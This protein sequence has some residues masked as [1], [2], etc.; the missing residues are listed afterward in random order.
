MTITHSPIGV[1]HLAS[2]V[3]AMLLG[4]YMLWADKGTKIHK[5]VGYAYCLSMLSVNAT[6][7]GIYYL[8]GRFGIFHGFALLSLFTLFSGMIPIIVRKN[9][10]TISLHLSFMYWSVIGL[11]CAFVAETLVRCPIPFLYGNLS[12][13]VFIGTFGVMFL[14]ALGFRKF[15]MQ[16]YY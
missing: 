16:K 10:Q 12:I 6:A 15:K 4:A 9:A 13:A 5:R 8:W 7:F 1:A 11:Y 2:S 14:G 3:I